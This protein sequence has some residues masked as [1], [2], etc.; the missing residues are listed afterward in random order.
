MKKTKKLVITIA[1]AS[2][3][4]FSMAFF[5]SQ[6]SQAG[7]GDS[8]SGWLW[9]GT[10]DGAG[11]NTGIGWISMNNINPGA[12][13]AISYGVSIPVS[14]G[15][16]SGYAWSENLGWINFSGASRSG[17]NIIGSATIQG[18]ADE[19][20]L[21][22][23]GGWQGRISLNG[24]AQ[25]NCPSGYTYNSANGKCEQ[26]PSCPS[27]GTYNPTSNRCEAALIPAQYQCPATGT[28]YST[29][30]S[31]DGV[32]RQTANCNAT[33]PT[34]SGTT[35]VTT[36]WESV[37]ANGSN[38]YFGGHPIQ[39]AGFSASG[40]VT[41]PLPPGGLGPRYTVRR[42]V[43]SSSKIDVY[44]SKPPSTEE[45]ENASQYAGSINLTDAIVSGNIFFS[46]YSEPYLNGSGNSLIYDGDA[47]KLIFSGIYY[48]QLSGGS[49][50][51]GNHQCSAPQACT[52][53]GESCLP[54]YSQSGSICIATAICSSGG[55]LNLATDKCEADPVVSGISYGVS[56][57]PADNTLSGY[58]WSDELGWIDF[59]RASAGC[60]AS[61]YTYSCM[62][63][64]FCGA[65]EAAETTNYWICNKT[66]NCGN[67]T[68]TSQ[69]ECTA[70]GITGCSN[71]ICPACAPLQARWRE[72]AP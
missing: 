24:T 53:T 44:C 33:S 12:G 70:N 43:G 6:K 29:Q 39:I 51:D 56:V 38:I 55:I 67:V 31:C 54:G 7:T 49:A 42:L 37:S 72:V 71:T 34:L 22:N 10:D 60:A 28:L 15:L 61:S 59:S 36:Y 1:L 50:C 45:A 27:G 8:S 16:L 18:I 4:I 2:L 14:D 3:I 21:G 13:G 41:C 35:W 52:S 23:S 57:N 32:C 19:A 64:P 63:G 46:P 20:A 47:N 40:S 30:S 65:C 48:C 69:D 17:N 68:T 58:G 5:Y 11:S 9:G 25:N 62:N 66:D 26:N